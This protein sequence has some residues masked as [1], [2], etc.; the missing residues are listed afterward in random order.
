MLSM[1]VTLQLI[2]TLRQKGVT[3]NARP[4]EGAS[5]WQY[6]LVQ[7]LPFLL[8]L[9]GL[10]LSPGRLWQMRRAI[11]GL[12]MAQVGIPFAGWDSNWTYTFVGAILFAA[13]LLNTVVRNRAEKAR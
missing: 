12:G 10:E 2:S 11:F 3:I 13:V 5:I 1:V 6:I 9:V 4:E 7:S 8:F